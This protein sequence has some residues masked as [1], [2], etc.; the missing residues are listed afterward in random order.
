[1]VC[2][3]KTFSQMNSWKNILNVQNLFDIDIAPSGKIFV[4]SY[5][6]GIWRSDDKGDNWIVLNFPVSGLIAIH[7]TS[8]N[9]IYV[10]TWGHGV[11]RS[12]DNGSTWTQTGSSTLKVNDI[13][14][15]SNGDVFIATFGD[16]ALY[17]STDNGLSWFSKI[18]GIPKQTDPIYIDAVINGPNSLLYAAGYKIYRSVNNGEDWS[19][20]GTPNTDNSV[21]LLLT[22]PGHLFVGGDNGVQRTTNDGLTWETVNFGSSQAFVGSLVANSRGNIF[23]GIGNG[24]VYY[25][26]DEGDNWYDFNSGLTNNEVS[27]LA[28]DTHGVLFASTSGGGLFRTSSSTVN[29]NRDKSNRIS[30]V[31]LAQNYPNPF[32]PTTTIKFQVP[33]SGFVTLKV[34]DLLGREVATLVNENMTQGSYERVFD[35]RGLSSGFFFYRL[36]SSTFIQTKKMI[37]LK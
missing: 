33:N 35:G 2:S 20:I 24:G 19:M 6:N 18:H 9:T 17:K 27:D 30:N 21:S 8:L 23:R 34:F 13:S 14:S 15:N 5:T 37:L 26:D 22:S 29:V 31:S 16:S 3:I 1:M 12:T 4:V 7:A 25:S 28:I 32:N 11:Y 36:K 10:G